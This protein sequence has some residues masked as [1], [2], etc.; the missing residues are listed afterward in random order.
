MKV[1]QDEVPGTVRKDMASRQGRSLGSL[2]R[3]WP[4]ERE[5]PSIVPSGTYHF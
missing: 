4:Y 1:A 2:S 3:R 5:Q